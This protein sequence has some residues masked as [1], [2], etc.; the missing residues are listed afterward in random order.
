MRAFFLLF[1]AAA[2]GTAAPLQKDLGEGLVYFRVHHL[3]ADLPADS[4][5]RSRPCVL[6]LRYVRGDAPTA[7]LLKTWLKAHAAVKSPVLLL[8]NLDT[9]PALLAPLASAQA[10]PGLVIIAPQSA[11]FAA[12]IS[13]PDSP[14]RERRAYD[15]LEQG[16]PVESLLDDNPPKPRNDEARLARDHISDEE[17][18]AETEDA[19]PSDKPAPPRPLVDAEL[20]RAVQLHRALLALKRL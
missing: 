9:S 12:D 1:L 19:P 11:T 14:R 18:E 15:A 16:T 4:A 13:V 10:I 8:A 2:A 17:M 7:A 6:D 3:P 20:Q 5:L